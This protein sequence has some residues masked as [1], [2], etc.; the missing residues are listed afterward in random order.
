M[1]RG[2]RLPPVTL[3]P[4]D[5]ETL[6]NWSRRRKTAQAL[7]L[8]SRIILRAS[9]GLTATAIAGELGVCIQPV[10]KW[11]R[12]FASLG[13]DGLLDEARPG[14][15]RKL[16]TLRSSASLCAHWRPSPTAPRTV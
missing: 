15:P 16:V 8:R 1:L 3:I 6:Q 4:G 11:W 7:A 5:H 10:S 13:P 9:T 2:R 12:C 14:Q